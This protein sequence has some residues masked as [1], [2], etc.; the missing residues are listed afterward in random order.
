VQHPTL[1]PD[2]GG[3]IDCPRKVWSI[4]MGQEVVDYPRGQVEFS[5]SGCCLRT[6]RGGGQFVRSRGTGLAIKGEGDRRLSGEHAVARS[7][8]GGRDPDVPQ[9]VPR[10]AL[11]NVLERAPLRE[12]GIHEAA[13]ERTHPISRRGLQQRLPNE[14]DEPAVGQDE[15]GC[16]G[17]GHKVINSGSVAFKRRGKPSGQVEAHSEGEK[18]FPQFTVRGIEFVAE[19]VQH[20]VGVE[21][22]RKQF[23]FLSCRPDGQVHQP[24]HPAGQ[25]SDLVDEG[26]RHRALQ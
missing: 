23:S 10:Q 21:R 6:P 12:Q 5:E 26:R 17:P 20:A 24:R 8:Q 14:R 16:P 1:S 22:I 3:N 7:L 2:G 11:G 25:L 18:Q 9:A 4:L 19:L 15:S 13:L